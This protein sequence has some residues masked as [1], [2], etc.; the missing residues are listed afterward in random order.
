[1]PLWSSTA[2]R[3]RYDWMTA[4]DVWRHYLCSFLHISYIHK[5][6]TRGQLLDA[7]SGD[8]DTTIQGYAL[9]DGVR[10]RIQFGTAA[11]TMVM[12]VVLEENGI[13]VCLPEA[14]IE[15][16][17]DYLLV[18]AA[19]FSRFWARRQKATR[20]IWY[21]RIRG[22]PLPI[23]IGWIKKNTFAASLSLGGL[24]PHGCRRAV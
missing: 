11:V 3:E 22:E 18:S 15:E 4:S 6:N 23:L 21:I 5:D 2:D 20:D 8:P 10:L 9:P 17:G 19:R 13:S 1:M 12:D 24:W 7:Y 16:N 14:G